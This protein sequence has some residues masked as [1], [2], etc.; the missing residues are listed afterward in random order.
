M[1]RQIVKK[2]LLG[3]NGRVNSLRTF[4]HSTRHGYIATTRAPQDA[5]RVPTAPLFHS[6]RPL[7]RSSCHPDFWALRESD[8]AKTERTQS[9]T[10][11]DCI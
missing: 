3:S 8:L 4:V 6:F 11:D 10:A 2:A 9:Q 7:R 5:Q 1:L